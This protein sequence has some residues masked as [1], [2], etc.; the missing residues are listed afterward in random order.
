MFALSWTCLYL[1]YWAWECL[2]LD[3]LTVG[4]FPNNFD[5]GLGKPNWWVGRLEKCYQ[6]AFLNGVI[7]A[8]RC[9]AI[10]IAF[11]H[12]Q[13]EFSTVKSSSAPINLLCLKVLTIFVKQ[14][15]STANYT[16]WTQII[17]C[18]AYNDVIYIYLKLR[19]TCMGS[20]QF[21]SVQRT[22]KIEFIKLESWVFMRW[23][24]FLFFFPLLKY[25]LI[26]AS[27]IKKIIW[28]NVETWNSTWKDV[29]FLLLLL[30]AIQKW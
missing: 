28:F 15:A 7:S 16:H 11:G 19:P 13:R 26:C 1:N 27:H 6:K 10:S 17:V 3:G 29:R 22:H 2:F 8:G 5:I 25:N 14:T 12:H 4:F 24:I 30:L 20:I 18:V 21:V 9:E 23:T